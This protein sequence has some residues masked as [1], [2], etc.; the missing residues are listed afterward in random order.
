MGRYAEAEPLYRR[1][2]KIREAKLGADHPD[3]ADSLNNL[4]E[5]YR[6]TGR[7]AEAEP[8]YQRALKIREVKLG[9][10]HPEHRPQPEQPGGTLRRAGSLG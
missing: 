4:A 3:T 2:L 1:G 5:L 8:L 6:S 10:D 7:S 9:A